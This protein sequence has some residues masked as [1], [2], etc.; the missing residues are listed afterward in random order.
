M[1]FN[2]IVYRVAIA[3]PSDTREARDAVEKALYSWNTSNSTSKSVMLFPWRWETSS[4]SLLGVHPQ[5]L[6]NKQGI[7]SADILIALF[8]SKLGT[9]TPEAVS[10]TVEEIERAVDSGKPVHLFFSKALLPTDVDTR[11]LDA[12]REFKKKIQE[13][14]LYKDFSTL[15]ELTYEVWRS[16]E[17]DLSNSLLPDKS[18]FTVAPRGVQIR[19]Q[20][21]SERVPTGSDSRGKIKYETKR[22]VDVY[23]DGD[24]D[25]L[26]VTFTTPEE[27][28]GV[29]LMAPERPIKLQ[30]HTHRK[31]D[32]FLTMS[33]S[34][35]QILVSWVENGERYEEMFDI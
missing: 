17:Y 32:V 14:G 30:A 8:G 18:S 3:S 29:F 9:P 35:P 26:E 23:N 31:I 33:S 4:V 5:E 12:L 16:I 20:T 10:G 7:D 22:W 34:D 28:Q 15:E 25:A 19:V 27:S 11:Q 21:Q 13:R 2:A 1:S 6:I 24:V